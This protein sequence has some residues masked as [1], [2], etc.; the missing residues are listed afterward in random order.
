MVDKFIEQAP[1]GE[2]TNPDGSE[3]LPV[4]NGT[5]DYYIQMLNLVARKLREAG[6]PT[7]LSLGNVPDGQFLRRSGSSIVGAGNAAGSYYT[8]YKI[9]P[10]V[11]ASTLTV[12]IKHIDGSDPSASNPLFFRVGDVEYS[13]T[14]AVAFNLG[15]GSVNWFSMNTVGVAGNDTDFFLYAIG[16]TGAS[17]GL[18]FGIARVP[19]ATRMGDLR[20]TTTSQRYIAGN[21]ANYNTS[22]PVVLL[23]RFNATMNT[24]LNWT[25]AG[26]IV[27]N[28]P[29]Y[30]TRWMSW[31]PSVTGFS[32]FSVGNNHYQVVGENVLW[33]A[34]ISG[35]SNSTQFTFSLPFAP[36]TAIISN[37]I[38]FIARITDNSVAGVAM[39]QFT[40]NNIMTCYRD[41]GG[42]A[43]AAAGSKGFEGS[44]FTFPIG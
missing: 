15:G 8:P 26:S 43:F 34:R 35:T 19:F 20:S 6:G 31:N 23:G 14:S 36:I 11:A 25:S 16:E 7:V 29:V 33:I 27:V 32:T 4:T 18:K 17:A 40:I 39:S 5:T 44:V 3:K 2:L 10:T 41:I 42:N 37:N 21:W 12:S 24:S 30:D 13:L 38:F 28:Y 9:V 22:D 1:G